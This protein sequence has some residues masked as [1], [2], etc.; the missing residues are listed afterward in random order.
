MKVSPDFFFD[1]R[2]FIFDPDSGATYSLNRTGAFVFKH[3]KGGAGM[4]DMVRL[5]VDAFDVNPKTARA[6][7]RDIMQQLVGLGLLSEAAD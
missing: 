4:E 3:L 2:G 1:E 7:M 6:D 5:L